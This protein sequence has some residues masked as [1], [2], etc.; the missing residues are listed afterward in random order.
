M[1]TTKNHRTGTKG[2]PRAQ[3]EQLILDAA[4]HE[5]AHHGYA[6]ASVAAIAQRSDIS[7]PLVYAYFN[8][9]EGLSQACLHRAGKP[10]VQAVTDAQL[11]APAHIRAAA[12]LQAIFTTLQPRPHDW[13]VLY[14]PTLPPGTPTTTAQHYRQRLNALGATGI[15]QILNHHGD[16]DPHDHDL[17]TQVWFSTVTTAVTWWLAHPEHSAQDMTHRCQ[18]LLNTLLT[19]PT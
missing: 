18:R 6:T 12:T 19:H 5:F 10:L 11:P 2:V 7:K 4:A 17:L 16:H 3:R 9:K 15:S 8:S 1:A 14:D 13:S